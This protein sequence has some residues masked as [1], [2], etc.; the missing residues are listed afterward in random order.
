MK[1][2]I[3]I[4]LIFSIALIYYILYRPVKNPNNFT[5]I[6]VGYASVNIDGLNYNEYNSSKFYKVADKWGIVFKNKGCVISDSIMT[7]VWENN[8]ESKINIE[9]KF[10]E[11]WKENFN[12]EVKNLNK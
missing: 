8:R 5:L 11:D 1:K 10:G 6:S 7:S 9:K 2:F 4:A 12:R 3:F